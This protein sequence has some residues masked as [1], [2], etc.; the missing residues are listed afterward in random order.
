DD[1]DY[2][3]KDF[4]R[5]Q[6]VPPAS[7]QATATRWLHEGYCE[8]R[9]TP[10]PD[11]ASSKDTLD[12]SKMPD[13][14]PPVAF[15]AP[16][17]QRAKLS[18]GLEIVLAESHKV[19]SVQMNLIVRGGWSGDQR[20]KIG[21]ASFMSRMQDEGTKKR[22]ALQISEETQL[23]GATLNTNSDV[24]RC[25]VNLNALKA[26]LQPSIDL[27]SDVVLNPA[28]PPEEIERQRQQV[29]GQIT[30]EKKQPVQ[31]GIRILPGLLYGDNHPYGQPLTGSG[32]EASVKA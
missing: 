26:R 13:V 32:T 4:A 17:L 6:A 16:K 30:Q 15:A 18:N 24:D 7:V 25:L 8:M 22:T 1:A 19:P 2:L 14:G 28:F 29:L 21:V 9:V 5:Y 31:M 20:D 27:W 11:L 12:R 10:Y 23:L 3:S